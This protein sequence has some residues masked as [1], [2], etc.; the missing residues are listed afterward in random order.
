MWQRKLYTLVFLRKENQILLGF[1]KRGFGVNKWNGFGGKVEPNES[2]VEA[3]ARE[4]KEE[5]NLVVEICDLKHIAHMEFTFEGE[6]TLMDVR[7]YST[8]KF[9]GTLKETEEMRPKWFILENIPYDQMW[10]DDRLW[11]PYMF[12][13]KL[14]H[15]RFHFLGHDKILNYKIEELESMEAHYNKNKM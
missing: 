2:I 14:V 10:L 15:G 9:T 1:K 3:A 7:V 12:K 5:C 8:N 13:G 4:L 6:P 11:F